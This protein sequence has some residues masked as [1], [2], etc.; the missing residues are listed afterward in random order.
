ML[1]KLLLLTFIVTSSINCNPE[2]ERLAR[3]EAVRAASMVALRIV[4]PTLHTLYA[5]FNPRI[6]A[7]YVVELVMKSTTK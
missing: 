7:Q 2:L 6:M 1:K 3:E 5:W 4:S